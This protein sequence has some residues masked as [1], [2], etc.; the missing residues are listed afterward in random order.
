V[1]HRVSLPAEPGDL[2]LLLTEEIDRLRAELNDAYSH[3]GRVD[4]SLLHISRR[5]DRIIILYER[6]IANQA[7]P[8]RSPTSRADKAEL[9]HAD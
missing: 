2:V 9:Y 7:S 3:A 4:E 1:E 5:L 6:T 8:M